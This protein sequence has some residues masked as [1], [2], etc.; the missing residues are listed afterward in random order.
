ME[1]NI[2]VALGE[3]KSLDQTKVLVEEKT[4]STSEQQSLVPVMISFQMMSNSRE[5]FRLVEV[6]GNKTLESLFREEEDSNDLDIDDFLVKASAGRSGSF[7]KFSP[8]NRISLVARILKTDVLW[9]IY[10]KVSKTNRLPLKNAFDILKCAASSQG[11]PDPIPSPFNQKQLLFNQVLGFLKERNVLFNKVDC[12]PRV[13]NRK[14]GAATEVVYEITDILWKIGQAEKQ[15]KSRSLWNKVPVMFSGLLTFE[16]KSKEPILLTQNSCEIFASHI[17]EVMSKVI[18]SSQIFSP[19]RIALLECAELFVRYSEYLKSNQISLEKKRI[20]DKSIKTATEA[21][22]IQIS[23]REKVS[24]VE[25]GN[26][27]LINASLAKIFEKLEKSEFYQPVNMSTMLPTNRNSRST[28]LHR[29]LIAQAPQKCVLWSFENGPCAPQSIFALLVD[30]CDS[31]Q[32][33]I[34]K[35]HQ[36]KSKLQTLQKFYFPREFYGQFYASMGTVTGI[37]SQDLK[38]VCSMVMGDDRRFDREVQKRF[39]EAVM[40]GDADFIYDM[41]HFN[42]SKIKY[43]EYITEFRNAVQE[44]MVEDRGRHE[45]QYD[46][47]IV[48]KVSFG[49]SLAQMFRSVCDRVKQKYPDCP[50]PKSEAMISRYLIPRTKAAADSA[51][52]SEPLIPLKLAMQQKVI[53]KPNIDAHYNAAQYKYLRS[54]AVKFG[55]DIVTMIGWDDKTGV[56]VGEPEQPTTATQH[57]RKS[58]VHQNVEVGEGQHSFHKTN[59]TPSVRLVHE[60]GTSIEDSFYRGLPQVVLKDAIFQPSNSARHATEVFQMLQKNPHLRKPVLVFTNDG[61]SDHNIRHE[62]NVVSMLALFLR[63]TDAIFM[64]N[65]QMAAYRSA[66]H[67]VEKLNCILNLAWNGVSL[68]REVFED[69]VLEKVFG[70]CTTMAEVRSKAEKHPGIKTSLEKSLLPA[71]KVLEERAKQASLKENMFEVFTAATDEQ[72]KEFLSVIVSIDPDFDVERYLD[73][74]KP[75]HYSPAIRDYIDKHITMTHYSLTF[76]KQSPL[77]REFLIESYPMVDWPGDLEPLPC[78]VLDTGDLTKFLDYEKVSALKNKDFFDKCRPGATVKTPTNIPFIKNKQR[79]M[80]GAELNITCETCNKQRVVYFQYKPSVS[81]ISA[82]KSALLHVRYYCG[83]RVSSCGRSLA[84]LEEITNVP[85]NDEELDDEIDNVTL[86]SNEVEKEA[87]I[88]DDIEDEFEVS[89][90]EPTRKKKKTMI[91]ES[92]ESDNEDELIDLLTSSE[93]GMV[94]QDDISTSSKH[95]SN[96]LCLFCRNFETSHKCRTCRAACCNLC[97]TI[98]VEDLGDIVCPN[99]NHSDDDK[100]STEVKKRGR[101]SK[102]KPDATF[103]SLSKKGRGRPRKSATKEPKEKEDPN[104]N[105]AVESEDN[106]EVIESMSHPSHL[107]ELRIIGNGNILRKLFV[108][109]SLSCQSPIEAHMYDILMTSKKPLPCSYC[110]EVEESRMT[111]KLSE[112]CFPLCKSCEL[113]GRGAAARRKSRK[114]VPKALKGKK[115]EVKSKK[116]KTRQLLI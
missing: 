40:S 10:E 2:S 44:Y 1:L 103:P 93:Q 5:C 107:T 99:C 25:P 78:P 82:A 61:G 73:K 108:D 33:M 111:S 49:F 109:E 51:S 70:Q 66:Y 30:P 106:D 21:V 36:L 4:Q 79:A 102:K 90:E 80:F 104:N 46:G 47:T 88:L 24:I 45:T 14:T 39:E 65:F 55:Q 69:P 18:V 50:L 94:V 71:R 3:G 86:D 56:D 6:D 11:L 32:T 7:D 85:F 81:D 20:N 34:G 75:Y 72:V 77:T 59:I 38:L 67:P 58:W 12:A 29:D 110:G 42:G 19:V 92:D 9:V 100:A 116:K 84:V 54:F 98:E 91:I 112:E 48:S 114:V 95:L 31:T 28:L 52:R 22:L 13:K 53:E 113:G 87:D 60:L 8:A 43:K 64:I 41:R 97:N 105:E 15:L 115:P 16:L 57:S 83:G 76:M 23:N 62:R 101:P 37:S 89:V 68:S 26:K 17:R 74:K 63:L 96:S 35:V 27:P